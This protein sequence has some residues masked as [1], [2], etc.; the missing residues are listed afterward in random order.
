MRAKWFSGRPGIL[1]E[2]GDEPPV[3]EI[4]G[5]VMLVPSRPTLATK[6]WVVFWN[7]WDGVAVYVDVTNTPRY[8][9]RVV[10]AI[11]L[12][13]DVVAQRDGGVEI[14]DVDE[15]DEH[16]V[17]LGYPPEVVD[18]ALWTADWLLHKIRAAAPP[19]DAT[20]RVWLSALRQAGPPEGRGCAE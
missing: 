7:L 1:Y 17:V 14:V 10:S 15:F 11:D 5:F 18:K 6:D 13:L 19:F 3:V 12:D 16:R 2:R 8:D 4:D 20:G 9:D